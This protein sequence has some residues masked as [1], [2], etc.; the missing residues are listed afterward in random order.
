MAEVP[1][2]VFINPL[3]YALH[4]S[5]Q[6]GADFYFTQDLQVHSVTP[7]AGATCGGTEVRAL[8]PFSADTPFCHRGRFVLLG[9]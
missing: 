4:A 5:P 6:T 7:S 3:G 1:V 2:H 8:L 9:S